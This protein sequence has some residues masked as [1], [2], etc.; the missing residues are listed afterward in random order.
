MAADDARGQAAQAGM[1]EVAIFDAPRDIVIVADA[2]EFPFDDV[3][4]RDQIGACAHLETEF[5]MAYLA[6]EA[7]A[8]EPV[9]E[10]HRAHAVLL[11]LMVEHHVRIFGMRRR[12]RQQSDGKEAA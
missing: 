9:G 3:L 12:R 1:A 7:D 8:V 11:G 5:E 2:A 10:D 6:T 4:H